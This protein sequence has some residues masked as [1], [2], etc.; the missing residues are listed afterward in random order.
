MCFLELHGVTTLA[1]HHEV[2]W[3]CSGNSTILLFGVPK[4]Q[5]G[6]ILYRQILLECL[7]IF[8]DCCIE[9]QDECALL[10]SVNLMYS[11]VFGIVEEL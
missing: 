9:V 5:Q 2:W 1:R 4:I 3:W 6:K 11:I 10:N 8:T 7:H